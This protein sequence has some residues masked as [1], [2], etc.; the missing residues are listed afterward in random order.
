RSAAVERLAEKFAAALAPVAPAKQVV[1]VESNVANYQSLLAQMPSG[2]EVVVLNAGKD[3]LSQM[4]E[5]A[6][7]H[8]GYAAIHVISH[9]Q[10]GD[11]M[12]GSV[13]LTTAKLDSRQADLKAIGQALSANGDILLYGCDIAAGSSGAA[14]VSALSRYT[15]ADVAASTDATG[16][17][18]LGGDWTLEHNSGHIDVDALSFDYK[19]LLA[20]PASQNFDSGSTTSNGTSSLSLG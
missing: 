12:L 11:L 18:R 19:G 10:S 8:H 17:A 7:T 14:F 3:G 2:M 4:A 20:V 1:F 9:G 5:W 6:K 16:A 15:Q 13:E